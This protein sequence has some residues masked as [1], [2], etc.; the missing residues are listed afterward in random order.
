MRRDKR[1]KLAIIVPT[2][3]RRKYLKRLLSQLSMQKVAGCHLDIVT[4]VD[5]SSDGT[6]EMLKNQFPDVHVVQGTG[7]WW[8][9]KSMNEGFKYVEELQP[10]YVLTLNDD[11]ELASNYLQSLIDAL[12]KVKAGSIIGSISVTMELPHRVTFSGV[13]ETIWWRS[14]KKTYLKNLSIVDPAEL[15]GIYPSDVLPGRGMLIPYRALIELNYFDEKFVQYGSDDDFCLRAKRAGHK[16]YVCWDAKVFSHH[17]LT[18]AGSPVLKPALTHYLKQLMNKY[19]PIYFP[20][21]VLFVWRHGRRCVFP[22]TIG[23]LI[24]G[25]I[26]T[27]IK[28][29]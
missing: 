12:K 16:V 4:V 21:N 20:K 25:I 29:R 19:S 8:Y 28:Y 18:G 1:L 23:I 26:K 14:K 17:K 7:N 22:I 27:F 3:N 13:K 24:L 11:V 2:F 10:D 5:G 6:F 9:T 15:T